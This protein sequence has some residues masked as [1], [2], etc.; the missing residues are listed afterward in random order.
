MRRAGDKQIALFVPRDSFKDRA[1]GITCSIPNPSA[2]MFDR[3][4][5][6]LPGLL[7]IS[8]Q[9]LR[10]T[11][12]TWH[13][14]RSLH[15]RQRSRRCQISPPPDRLRSIGKPFLNG[16]DRVLIGFSLPGQSKAKSIA[17]P[18]A[19]QNEE[20]FPSAILRQLGSLCHI[21]LLPHRPHAPRSAVEYLSSDLARLRLH[22]KEKLCT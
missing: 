7:A 21:V 6:L 1:I 8:R 17:I 11:K 16:S 2:D 4:A 13:R 3:H 22:E 9:R 15:K 10:A 5:I 18:C 12:R 14:T 19:C 20:T